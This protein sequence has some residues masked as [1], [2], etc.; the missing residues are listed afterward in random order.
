MF[1]SFEHQTRVRQLAMSYRDTPTIFPVRKPRKRGELSWE[2]PKPAVLHKLLSHPISAG[3]YA[4]G[5]TRSFIDYSEGRLIKRTKRIGLSEQ[6]KVCIRGHHEAYVRGTGIKAIRR[7]WQ[8]RGPGGRW[9]TTEEPF[10]KGVRCWRVSCDVAT[11]D[12]SSG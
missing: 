10:G 1:E 9:M 12:A 2:L 7:S 3:V 8:R 4:Y 6:W 11:A 5:R